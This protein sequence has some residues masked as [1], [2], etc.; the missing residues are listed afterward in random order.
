MGIAIHDEGED[1]L[2]PY[3]AA[4]ALD[5]VAAEGPLFL[6]DPHRGTLGAVTGTGFPDD[7]LQFPAQVVSE[8]GAGEVD[9]V[10]DEPSHA[11]VAGVGLGFEFGEE[12]LLRAA[13]L[14]EGDKVSGFESVVGDDDLEIE[15]GFVGDEAVQLEGLFASDVD[16]ASQADEAV[17]LGPD[18]GLP[19][20]VEV[21][22]VGAGLAPAAARLDE[23]LELG[24]ALEGDGDGEV[25][26]GG[27]EG[28]DDGIAEEGGIEPDLDLSAGQEALDLA[29]TV[30][31]EEDG[32]VG[33]VDVPWAVEEVE[34]LTGLSDGAEEGVVASSS[35]FHLV[36]AD[37]GSLGVPAGGVHGAVEV[38]GEPW[39]LPRDEAVQNEGAEESA[40]ALDT[41]GTGFGEGTADGGD[42]GEAR[43]AEE[44]EDHGILVIVAGVTQ[45][46]V[47]QEE[48]DD[49]EKGDACET[50]DGTGGEMVEAIP[51]AFLKPQ[52][53]KEPLQDDESGEGGEGL[54]FETELG[55]AVA[56]GVGGGA[57]EVHSWD[58]LLSVS[59]L[60]T[61]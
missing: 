58:G 15:P 29:D 11:D 8:G 46:A 33:V 35:L 40:E 60:V 4:S 56:T 50:V 9:L 17:G 31:D 44:P 49:E 39:G 55:Y 10:G 18:L 48:V 32:A 3:E 2:G 20:G 28:G 6:E 57:A 38:E 27:V 5:E 43:E 54:I 25:D 34:D 22:E 36:E 42:I 19:G 7:H 12:P 61:R 52:V 53:V 23:S 41:V 21:A 30:E 47:A 24:E 59:C 14:M 37:G 45:F 13:S 26:P 51:E 16:P 1:T